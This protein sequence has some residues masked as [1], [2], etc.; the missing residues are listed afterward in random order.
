[1]DV[2]VA[3][4]NGWAASPAAWSR[5][6]FPCMTSMF[7][8]VEQ[9]DGAVDRYMRALR[10]KAVLAAWSMGGTTAMRIAAEY[11]EKTAG[12]I[13]AAATPRLA[14]D[15]STGWRGM[16]PRRIEALR[17]GL[18]MTGGKG[19][20]PQEPGMPSPYM[21]D[22]PENLERGLEFLRTADVRDMLDRIPRDIPS[23]LFQSESDGIVRSSGVGFI[24]SHIPQ[25]RV[26]MVAGSE[27]ALPVTMAGE[28]SQCAREILSGAAVVPSAAN[29][30]VPAGETLCAGGARHPD[31]VDAAEIAA[32]I[33]AGGRVVLFMRHARRPHLAACDPTFGERL[34]VTEAGSESARALGR[35]LA[36]A[37]GGAGACFA[38]SPL[39]R[40]R[41]TAQAVAEGMGLGGAEVAQDP[42]LGMETPYF[43]DRET[44]W[45]EILER[46]FWPMMTEYLEN[47]EGPGFAPL[48][49]ATREMDRILRGYARAPLAVAVSHDSHVA[50]Y[51]QAHGACR[52][53]R[54][55]RWIGFLDSAAAMFSPDG[56]LDRV[57]YFPARI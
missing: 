29:D 18:L 35:L 27:H 32:R 1:M 34:P 5:C 3:I 36:E 10:G 4:L 14:E 28:I 8:Y 45:R 52:G 37:A 16:S 48:A 2:E 42:L 43:E 41:M 15:K 50:A 33:A 39:V 23:Y 7:G 24:V 47:G 22:T 21:L 51:L 30:P 53:W 46:G 13:L 56:A 17:A 9:L 11:P 12:L 38:S 57:A 44:V 19:L 40:S 55:D 25:T 6:E 20:F 31:V 49:A 26:R 54:Q